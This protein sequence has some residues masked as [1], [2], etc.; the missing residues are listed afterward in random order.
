MDLLTIAREFGLPL[1]L[2]LAAIATGS[3]GLWCW[4]REVD[5]QRL[6]AERAEKQRDRWE[7]IAW[8]TL[9]EGHKAATLASDATKDTP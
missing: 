5:E 7:G 4:K 2:V 1:A 9:T 6:R 3:K 8:S